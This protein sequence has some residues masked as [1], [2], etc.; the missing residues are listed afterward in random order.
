MYTQ[1]HKA[2]CIQIHTSCL[3]VHKQRHVC[4]CIYIY[5]FVHMCMNPTMCVCINIMYIYVYNHLH[6]S[7]GRAHFLLMCIHA[8]MLVCM[9]VCMHVCSCWKKRSIFHLCKY[10]CVCVCVCV[11]IYIYIYI[12]IY[13]S[14]HMCIKCMHT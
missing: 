1:L 5:V 3:Y 14:T 6:I 12:Y 11:C 13:M 10:T 2:T 9:Y 7:Q 4:V 8:R